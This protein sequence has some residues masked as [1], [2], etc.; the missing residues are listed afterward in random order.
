MKI[1]LP[2]LICFLFCFCFVGEITSA[3]RNYPI[4]PVNSIN[5]DQQNPSM[6][7]GFQNTKS[8]MGNLKPNDCIPIQP[9]NKQGPKNDPLNHQNF[10]Y[11][12]PNQEY[13]PSLPSNQEHPPDELRNQHKPL[14]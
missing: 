4:D 9:P 6:D 7:P 14:Y 1:K 2:L 10:H 13:R 5:F 11:G 8:N 12:S 3:D